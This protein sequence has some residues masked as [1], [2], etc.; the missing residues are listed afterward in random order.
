MKLIRRIGIVAM[1]L[2]TFVLL[3]VSAHEGR[4]V[5]EYEIELGW[6]VEPAYTGQINGVEIDII[7][8]ASSEGFEGAEITLQVEAV[9]GPA[10]KVL[11]LAADPEQVG[12]YTATLIPTRPGDYTFRLFGTIGETSVD[13]TFSAAEGQF[14]TV[15]PISDLQFPDG[16][17]SR[18]NA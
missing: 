12:H 4:E 15:E 18:A 13:E 17:V 10:K 11:N 5:G 9:F 1:V 8:A 6:Q 7:V 16:E 3:P 2:M 14:S